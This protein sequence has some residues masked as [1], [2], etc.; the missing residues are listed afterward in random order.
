[1]RI[2]NSK[3]YHPVKNSKEGYNRIL[4]KINQLIITPGQPGVIIQKR[5]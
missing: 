2:E 1:M 3:Q 5:V 4:I